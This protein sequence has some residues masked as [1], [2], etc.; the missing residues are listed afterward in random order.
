M[1]TSKA[2]A[3]PS[4]KSSLASPQAFMAGQLKSKLESYALQVRTALASA[5]TL[6]SMA[7]AAAAAEAL[8]AAAEPEPAG[9]ASPSFL[10]PQAAVSD[11]RTRNRGSRGF[12]GAP[13]P[14]P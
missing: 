1:A 3:F 5:S 12:M 10:L 7:G 8:P 6:G 2:S 9:A 14:A 4:L 13:I 11:A